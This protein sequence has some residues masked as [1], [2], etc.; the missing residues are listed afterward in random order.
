MDIPTILA[1]SQKK[2]HTLR[3]AEYVLEKHEDAFSA[4]PA[5]ANLT[6]HGIVLT[7]LE[8]PIELALALCQKFDIVFTR[9]R[10][11]AGSYDWVSEV[12]NTPIIL[13][14]VEFIADASGTVVLL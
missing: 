6:L 7:P 10:N 12:Y 9:Q 2:R 8:N 11:D 4:L 14:A 1:N 13:P 5:E 3:H